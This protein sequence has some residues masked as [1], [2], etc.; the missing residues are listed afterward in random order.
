MIVVSDASPIIN[1]A[2]IGKLD[3]LP[4]LYGKIILPIA[5][6]EEITVAG[7]GQPGD[8]EVRT[9][10]WIEVRSC[11]NLQLVAALSKEI[12]LGEAQAIT[13]AIEMNCDW[14]IIDERLGR[15]K[16]KVS[17]LRVVGIIGILLE[18]KQKQLLDN[19]TNQMDA[20]IANNF[21]IASEL[22]AEVKRIAGE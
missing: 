3:L 10:S 20:L 16:A 13:L 22:Y 9:A 17:S 12:D 1:L 8:A 11:Q 4:D 14:L 15:T 5:V 7:A 6:F 21:W 19:V 2:S 18:A